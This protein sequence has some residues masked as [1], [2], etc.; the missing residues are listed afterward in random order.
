MKRMKNDDNENHDTLGVKMQ[1]VM[2][3]STWNLK[4]MKYCSLTEVGG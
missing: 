3:L 4:I 2:N 1:F